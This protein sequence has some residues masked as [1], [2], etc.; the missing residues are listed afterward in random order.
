M[1]TRYQSPIAAARDTAGGATM[2]TAVRSRALVDDV[3]LP[4]GAVPEAEGAGDAVVTAGPAVESCV[5]AVDV[6][7]I[8]HLGVFRRSRRR[9]T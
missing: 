8:R 5:I 9:T 4:P 6:M 2:R 1:L 7:V 3:V